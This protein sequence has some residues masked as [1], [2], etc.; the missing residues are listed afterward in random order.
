MKA[1][2]LTSRS[3]RLPRKKSSS[4][5]VAET[6][7]VA[8]KQQRFQEVFGEVDWEQ[9]KRTIAEAKAVAR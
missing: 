7:L 5:S 9:A 6:E 1:L 3:N 4:T 8:A 2:A